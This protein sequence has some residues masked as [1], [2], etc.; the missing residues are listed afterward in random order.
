MP[1]PLPDRDLSRWNVSNVRSMTNLFHGAT[2]FT[3]DLSAWD[4]S[5]CGLFTGTFREA[6]N[7]NSDLTL[8][9]VSGATD[10]VRNALMILFRPLPHA[11]C[12]TLLEIG[13]DVF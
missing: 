10:M 7:F 2:N 9:D 13:N 1:S 4:V 5:R 6:H 12:L 3:S 8:W 11:I